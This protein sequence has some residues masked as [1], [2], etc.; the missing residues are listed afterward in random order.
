VSGAGGCLCGAVRYRVAGPL[1][2]VV[3]CHCGQ[4][5]RTSGHHVAATSAAREDVTVAGEVAWY[6]S[7]PGA[8]RG[9][10]RTCGSSLF[11]EDVGSGRL[12]I[13]AGTLDAPTG[14]RLRGHIFTAD[15]GDYYAIADG[16]PQA[17]GRDPEITAP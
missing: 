9:F 6:A 5:R 12:A 1:R 7:S 4:C 8:R 3:A 11:W 2:D 10:C 17:P 13:S 14:L 16:L 15:K